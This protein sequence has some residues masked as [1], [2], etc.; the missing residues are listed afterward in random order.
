MSEANGLFVGREEVVLMTNNLNKLEHLK[1]IRMQVHEKIKW[2]GKVQWGPKSNNGG[3]R[4]E[5][6]MMSIRSVVKK[7]M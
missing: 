4:L 5:G 7:W 1:Y 6:T 3:I 2:H